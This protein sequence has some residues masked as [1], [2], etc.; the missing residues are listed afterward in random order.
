MSSP[1]AKQILPAKEW[2]QLYRAVWRQPFAHLSKSE[3]GKLVRS[4]R[5][6]P[7]FDSFEEAND[8]L[9]VLQPNAKLHLRVYGCLL[10]KRFHI[11]NHHRLLDLQR[12]ML[13][14]EPTRSNRT[15]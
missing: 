5:G 9:E 10:C 14:I 1:F 4:C 13:K 8:M 7:I 12:G 2:D 3:R 15:K 6:K 11:A